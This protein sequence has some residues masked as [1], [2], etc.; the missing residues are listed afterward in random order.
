MMRLTSTSD[1]TANESRLTHLNDHL[2]AE[3]VETLT[4]SRTATDATTLQGAPH[5]DEQAIHD[6]PRMPRQPIADDTEN[7]VG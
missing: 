6:R 1:T 3:S 2:D 5:D 7:P 4:A